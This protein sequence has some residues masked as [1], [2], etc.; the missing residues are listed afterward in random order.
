MASDAS[1]EVAANRIAK[2]V[3]PLMTSRRFWLWAIIL[4]FVAWLAVGFSPLLSTDFD[5]SI[6]DLRFDEVA[7]QA[8]PS[9]DA[10]ADA[11]ADA[12]Y[13]YGVDRLVL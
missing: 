13:P 4:S 7:R 2:F 5:A 11:K 6:V 9:G 10:K 3:Q 8:L 12:K 1:I